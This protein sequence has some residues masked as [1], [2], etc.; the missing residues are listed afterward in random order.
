MPITSAAAAPVK[1]SSEI[2]CTAKLIPRVTTKTP[3]APETTAAT[4]P[5]QSAL[6]TKW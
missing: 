5:A 3:I 6:W 4:A 2:A 1:P